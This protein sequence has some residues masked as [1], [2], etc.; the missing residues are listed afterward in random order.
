VFHGAF[1]YAIAAGGVKGAA[2]SAFTSALRF[3]AGVA[4]R[5]CRTFGTRAWMS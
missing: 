4:A 2:E 3:A 5:S 1:T